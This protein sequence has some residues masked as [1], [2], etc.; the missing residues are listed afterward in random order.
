MTQSEKAYMIVGYDKDADVYVRI[1][2]IYDELPVAISVADH[3]ATLG[4]KRLNGERFDWLEVVTPYEGIRHHVAQ[5]IDDKK[6]APNFAKLLINVPYEVR[7]REETASKLRQVSGYN[8][9]K[10]IELFAA[11]YTL[12]PPKNSGL[13]RILGDMV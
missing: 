3:M 9:E 8:M 12:E 4:L 1:A 6:T 13:D 10:L 2:T 7:L 11:G 5:C